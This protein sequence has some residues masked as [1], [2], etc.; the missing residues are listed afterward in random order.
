MRFPIVTSENLEGRTFTLPRDFDGE[1]NVVFVAF[2]RRQQRDVDSW[3]P[4]VK[5][6]V[7]R[8][9]DTEYYEIPTIKRMVAPMR[10]MI[11]RGMRGGIDDRGARERTITL[12]LD[13]EPFK[14]ALGITVEQEIHVLVVDRDGQVLWRTAGAFSDEKGQ[15]LAR[16]L[17]TP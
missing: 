13:K 3:V 7:A 1:R 9:P 11:N 8:T 4:F 12:Y 16:A 10:W 5:S 2:E 6:L 15:G 14:R 17:T